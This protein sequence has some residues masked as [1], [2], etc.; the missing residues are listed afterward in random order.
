MVLSAG[1]ERADQGTSARWALS[2][3]APTRQIEPDPAQ[4]P[5]SDK[6]RNA[7]RRRLFAR[8]TGVDLEDQPS[9][10]LFPGTNKQSK[11]VR[12]SLPNFKILDTQK[13]YY[14]ASTKN[15]P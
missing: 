14:Q 10:N 15:V 9:R 8:Q 11:P 4:G 12:K 1:G 7:S 5:A 2:P 13:P 6:D 3:S